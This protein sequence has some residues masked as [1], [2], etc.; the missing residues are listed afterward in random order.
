M[1]ADVHLGAHYGC[2]KYAFYSFIQTI[3]EIMNGIRRQTES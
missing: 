1:F 2:D 3:Y